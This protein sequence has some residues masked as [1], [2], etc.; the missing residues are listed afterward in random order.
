MHLNVCTGRRRKGFLSGFFGVFCLC[1]LVVTL[2]GCEGNVLEGISDDGSKEARIEEARIALDNTR[3]ASAVS[4]L[5][6]L[7]SDFPN[8]PEVLQLLASAYSGMA[9]LDIFN[10]L[11]AIDQLQDRKGDIDVVGQVLGDEEGV[12]RG[13][14]I[15]GLKDNLKNAIDALGEISSL[16]DDQKVQLGLISLTRAALTIADAIMEERVATQVE[17]TE[18]GISELY[19]DVNVNPIDFDFLNPNDPDYVSGDTR[20]E[21]L[22]ADIVNVGNAVVVIADADNDLSE[23]FSEFQDAINPD[24]GDVTETEIENYVTSLIT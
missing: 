21:D 9:R 12:V 7:R 24:G 2:A 5:L 1:L 13:E 10:L 6:A 15:S 19:S 14:D 4:L 22:S 8:D 16:T 17:L 11:E 18:A 23:S 20:L 3:Y